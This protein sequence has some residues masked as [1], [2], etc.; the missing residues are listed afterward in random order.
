[1][2]YVITEEDKRLLLLSNIKY[3]FRINVADSSGKL[4]DSIYGISDFGGASLNTDSDIRRTTSFTLKLEDFIND[5]ESKITSWMGLFYVIDIGIYNDRIDDY[6]WYPQGK[7]KITTASTTYNKTSNSISF[8]L[9]DRVAELNGTLNGQQGGAPEIEIPK[10]FN[11]AMY[12][13]DAKAVSGSTYTFSVTKYTKY[14]DGDTFALEITQNNPAGGTTVNINSIG[15]V[16]VMKDGAALPADAFI[17]GETHTIKLTST[18][19]AEYVGKFTTRTIKNVAEQLIANSTSIKESIIEDVGEFSG[20]PDGNN[21]CMH[22]NGYDYLTYRQMHP[23]WNAL[24]YDLSYSAGQTV[25]DM[26]SEIRDLYPN[27]QMYFDCYDNFCFELIPNLNNDIVE[28]E[29]SYLQKILLSEGAESV[30][31]DIGAIKNITEIFGKSYDVDYYSNNEDPSHGVTYSNGV[32]SVS[33]SEYGTEYVNSDIIAF[34]IPTSATVTDNSVNINGIGNM[35]LYDEYTTKFTKKEMLEEG[36]TCVIKVKKDLVTKTYCAY[37]LGEYQPHGLS[38]LTNNAEDPVFTKEYFSTKYNIDKNYISFR[39]N[40]ESNFAVQKLGEILDVK[41]GG[42]F[43]NIMSNS[44]AVLN[45][46]Y[47][48]RISSTMFDTITLNTKMI[49][50]LDVNTKIQYKKQQ[51]AEPQTYI[52]KTRSD[53]YASGTSSLTLYKFMKMYEDS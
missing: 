6:I 16:S 38:V 22:Q 33:N 39:E 50:W 44:N 9:S 36:N 5:I 48:N 19:S 42:E 20:T 27:Y 47:Y 14:T 13:A 4:V 15:A 2:K 41:T 25:W 28:L 32:Y 43:D 8:D 3:K 10:A 1:M 26:L 52:L 7:Y 51:E 18:S 12:I 24:P 30:S 40:K 37:Y 34:V 23:E 11:N 29:D 21:Y 35:P 31:Y 45:A 17:A 46:D 49:P 53:N